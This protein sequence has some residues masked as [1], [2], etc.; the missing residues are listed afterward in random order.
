MLIENSSYSQTPSLQ[1]NGHLQTIL[2][3]FRKINDVEYHRIRIETLDNDFLDIDTIFKGNRKVMVLNHGL[4][5]NSNRPYVQS[6]A[7][8]F[9]DKKWD[10]IAWNCRSCSGEMNR[11]FKMYSHGDTEDLGT[12]IDYFQGEY[13]EIVLVGFSM[14]GNILLKY[15]G[16]N[17]DQLN[18]KIKAGI[19][20]SAPIQ[21]HDSAKTLNWKSN[22]LY[23]KKFIKQLRVKIL[24]KNEDYPG[25][26][27]V[28]KLDS[29]KK[30]ED[31]D[32]H[33]SAKLC[34]LENAAEFYEFGSA[35]NFISTIQIPTLIVNAKNDPILSGDCY[36]K[37]FLMHHKFITL[38]IPKKGGHVGFML[39]NR[40]DITWMEIRTEQFLDELTI[41]NKN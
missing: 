17:S 24:K 6:M 33:F 25:I 1:F 26:L 28:S 32:H 23:K 5:G 13:H 22:Y 16:V 9:S 7:K 4:E 35:L 8:Y 3:T 29:L 31:F 36:P 34:G 12:V 19:A 14:G 37:D 38:E 20:F 2:P 30:W 15:L 40:K 10:I 18:P 41:S 21:L 11:Q 39:K 27:D